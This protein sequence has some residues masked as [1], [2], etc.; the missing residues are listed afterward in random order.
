MMSDFKVDR[1]MDCVVIKV[2]GKIVHRVTAEDACSIGNDIFHH[3]AK[4]LEAEN[5][6]LMDGEDEDSE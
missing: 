4:A 5:R 6:V 1:V 3:A 2:D